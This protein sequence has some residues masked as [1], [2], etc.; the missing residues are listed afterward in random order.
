[1]SNKDS[2]NKDSSFIINPD[3][4]G[5]NASSSFKRRSESNSNIIVH[6][7][8]SFHSHQLLPSFRF[9]FSILFNNLI[10]LQAFKTTPISYTISLALGNILVDAWDTC[11]SAGCGI[12][13]CEWIV[14]KCVRCSIIQWPSV[15]NI[16]TCVLF[17]ALSLCV[18][19][20]NADKGVARACSSLDVL[21]EVEGIG[22]E[23]A[24][25]LCQTIKEKAQ[26]ERER[27]ELERSE[28]KDRSS[29]EVS[30]GNANEAILDSIADRLMIWFKKVV[31]I[32]SLPFSIPTCSSLS[33][34]SHSALCLSSTSSS[35]S[36]SKDKDSSF[37]QT[38][39]GIQS[40]HAISDTLLSLISFFHRTERFEERD[41]YLFILLFTQKRH[42]NLLE[43]AHVTQL[44]G[45]LLTDKLTDK[46]RS[47][48]SQARRS[49]S[50]KEILGL[51][52]V[53]IAPKLVELEKNKN[54]LMSQAA[55]IF[56]EAKS[57]APAF[58][59]LRSLVDVSVSSFDLDEAHALSQR[60]C[61]CLHELRHLS[62]VPSQAMMSH[63]F[64]P[65]TLFIPNH[66]L[67]LPHP[68][69]L[70]CLDLGSVPLTF[71]DDPCGQAKAEQS[72]CLKIFVGRG[73]S[74]EKLTEV[75]EDIRAKGYEVSNFSMKMSEEEKMEEEKR[76]EEKKKLLLQND[77]RIPNSPRK[78]L[79]NHLK[80]ACV[81]PFPI[82]QLLSL[83]LERENVE[84]EPIK[85]SLFGSLTHS[86]VF[87]LLSYSEKKYSLECKQCPSTML[88]GCSL[89]HIC[90][91]N[92]VEH[93]KNSPESRS[94]GLAT[95]RSFS[96]SSGEEILHQ[97][98]KRSTSDRRCV[99]KDDKESEMR[100]ILDTIRH[101]IDCESVSI[102][103]E[104]G[105]GCLGQFSIMACSEK[106]TRDVPSTSYYQVQHVR[107]SPTVPLRSEK[108]KKK[109]KHLSSS[110]I[111]GISDRDIPLKDIHITQSLVTS[112]TL[113][114]LKQPLPGLK[115]VAEVVEKI[116]IL[117]EPF[118]TAILNVNETT[119][120][121]SQS[122]LLA[123]KKREKLNAHL[124]EHSSE[125]SDLTRRISGILDAAV[126]GG[127]KRLMLAFPILKESDEFYNPKEN[128]NNRSVAQ[129]VKNQLR[130]VKDG[131]FEISQW[132]VEDLEPLQRRFEELYEGLE[133]EIRGKWIFE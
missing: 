62:L 76:M 130:V 30:V 39:L 78:R 23:F 61:K 79:K 41:K 65:S 38:I 101:Y 105:D 3:G 71:S 33:S 97:K 74:N 110:Q 84:F 18:Y 91:M 82:T 121:L 80:V 13:L 53:S 50:T 114:V 96:S 102:S 108:T 95:S 47:S 70:F 49:T 99:L 55:A 32:R 133:E 94:E 72:P 64:T 124:H 131:L 66:A 59:I 98:S 26:S 111:K 77:S 93:I 12:S 46:E 10:T 22:F 44:V 75:V 100:V 52:E 129:A 25:K 73:R 2:S 36:S 17:S 116:T 42:L 60:M 117:F 1:T 21:C 24:E 113:L 28:E 14:Q 15:N 132:E 89:N 40:I 11:V 88:P 67:Q 109:E 45:L 5:I 16:I 19:L 125:I 31:K 63:S 119:E 128:E 7:S 126:N 48:M 104:R 37:S 86:H 112:L 68:F 107:S 34:L 20:G 27:R 57:F 56:M 9:L 43:T 120:T 123:R 87:D 69:F 106:W 35:S 90:R 127:T 81:T 6:T 103:H 118:E 115:R 29:E 58:N 54:I 83:L 85:M 51:D 92:I 4:L 8:S 122:I